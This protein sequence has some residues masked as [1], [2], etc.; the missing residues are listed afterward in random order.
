MIFYICATGA[1]NL[2]R[3]S[4]RLANGPAGILTQPRRQSANSLYRPCARLSGGD[5]GDR[6]ANHGHCWVAGSLRV[7]VLAGIERRDGHLQPV[8]PTQ[9]G[10]APDHAAA[11]CIP[12][13]TG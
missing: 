4:F 7:I 5:N 12:A 3:R 11:W 9:P 2:L 10:A 13:P 1:H 8:P 6:P